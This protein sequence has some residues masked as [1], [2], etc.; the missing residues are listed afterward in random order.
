MT[1]ALLKRGSGWLTQ[2]LQL[3]LLLALLPH[4]RR[5]CRDCDRVDHG[6]QQLPSQ[7]VSR[8]TG[9][10]GAVWGS[11]SWLVG[12]G[13]VPPLD[14]ASRGTFER[15]RDTYGESSLPCVVRSVDDGA[16]CAIGSG[17]RCTLVVDRVCV[18]R[19]LL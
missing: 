6:G 10:S 3:N 13:L 19:H 1:T 15:S 11:G 5:G 18:L 4:L 8:P 17:H 9:D 2:V 14:D 16:V 12:G 7:A